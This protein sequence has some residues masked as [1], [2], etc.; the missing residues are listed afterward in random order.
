MKF[1]DSSNFSFVLVY[2]S[3]VCHY[4]I[5]TIFLENFDISEFKFIKFV[6]VQDA[7]SKL[8][9]AN[10]K[11]AGRMLWNYFYFITHP[12]YYAHSGSL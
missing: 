11:K 12:D 4:Y 1:Y 9:G 7:K 6:K 8:S 10:F 5:R 2:I 3:G